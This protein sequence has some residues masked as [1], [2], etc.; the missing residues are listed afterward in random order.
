MAAPGAV[1]FVVPA[2]VLAA[3][4]GTSVARAQ[5]QPESEGGPVDAAAPIPEPPPAVDVPPPA[6][7]PAPAGKGTTSEGASVQDDGFGAAGP[8]RRRA[9]PIA[10]HDG[11]LML[12]EGPLTLMPSGLLHFDTY[13]FFGPGVKDYQRADGTGL[14]TNLEGRRIRLELGG[15]VFEK[16]YFLIG[17]Q[18]GG[19]GGVN[20]TVT[21]LNNFVGY[22]ASPMLRFQLGQF[23]VPFTVDNVS[24]IRWNDFMERS[25]TAS[26]VGAPLVRDLGAMVWG[27]TSRSALW[28]ALGYFGGEGGNRPSTDNRGD[29][30]GRLMFRPLWKREDALGQLHV[31]VSGRYGRRDPHYTRY[32]VPAMSTPGGYVFW[33]PT[34]TSD[35]G[36]VQVQPSGDQS[37]VSADLFVPIRRLDLRV[38][39]VYT[40]DGR[41]E[42]FAA[43]PRNIERAG[44]LSGYG[45]YVQ[46]TWWAWGEPRIA[47]V[48]GHYGPPPETRSARARALSLAA[49]WEQI[50]LDYDSIDRSSRDDGS[51][52]PGVR[53]GGIDARTTKLRVDAVQVAATYWATQHVKVMAQWSMYRFPGEPGENQ[54]T[55][56]GTQPNAGIADASV[57]HEVS[58]RVQLSL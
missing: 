5:G 11:R 56:P 35:D 1:R 25:L 15:R 39:G 3:L 6:E 50:R 36:V 13:S 48:P 33:S 19:P 16:W 30:V 37:A 27:G 51:L 8:R 49:R 58:A 4:C 55:A 10:Y 7:P 2:V 41:R 12:H 9:R 40:H 45:Y 24:A 23:R 43:T 38:E 47:G 52:V 57:L 53:R 44:T 28:Y 22:E 14:K 17:V 21:P 32:A 26:V 18:A 31:G 29:V 46:A 34:Y 54:A 42:V 20:P